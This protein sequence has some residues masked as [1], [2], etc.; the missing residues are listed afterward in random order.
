VG[1]AADWEHVPEEIWPGV[2]PSVRAAGIEVDDGEPEQSMVWFTCTRG[3]CRVHLGYAPDDRGR[4]VV[5]Y[6][7]GRAFWWRPLAMRR[8]FAD[9]VRAVE[10][11]GGRPAYLNGRFAGPAQDP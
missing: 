6:S 9:V 3:P 5:V 7:P 11:A 8:L 4:E 2:L 1:V 10:A